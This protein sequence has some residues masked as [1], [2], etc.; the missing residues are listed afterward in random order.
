MSLE[1]PDL[2]SD[3]ER[4]QVIAALRHHAAAGL[5]SLEDFADR[6]E[7]VLI[8]QTRADLVALTASLPALV[9]PAPPTDPPRRWAVGVL[10]GEKVRGPWRLDDHMHAVALLGSAQID[11]C[12]AQVV[13]DE[14]TIYIVALFGGVE[15]QVP[16]GLPV[17]LSGIAVMGTPQY[18]VKRCDPIAGMPRVRCVFALCGGVTVRRKFRKGLRGRATAGDDRGGRSPVAGHASRATPQ[19]ADGRAGRPLVL[20]ASRGAQADLDETV[21]VTG[22]S[23]PELTGVTVIHNERWAEGQASSLQAAVRHA[24][25]AG[26]EAIVVGVG[27]QPGVPAEAWRAVATTVT[28]PIVVATYDGERRSPVRLAKEIWPL[29]P[30]EGDE[31]ARVLM[32]SRPDLVSE[33]ACDG[34]P[35]D[36]D[37]L[38]DLQ[39]WS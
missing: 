28:S 18:K 34:D 20:W 4:D 21:V 35:A 5:L 33:V 6:V 30:S 9:E 29:L 1:R 13:G 27:D 39:R 7:L 15:V 26:H 17:E 24:E 2:V 31:G 36:V 8:A 12:D 14:A 32:R 3:S 16:E 25:E 11:L 19:A 22:A 10:S 37:T 38:E 23:L